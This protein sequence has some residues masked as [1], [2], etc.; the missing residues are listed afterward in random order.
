MSG[1]ALSAEW[2]ATPLLSYGLPDKSWHDLG[3]SN[4]RKLHPQ[5][6]LTKAW[7]PHLNLWK[8]VQPG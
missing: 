8:G 2:L 7:L 1:D 3:T 5:R 4:R 6:L